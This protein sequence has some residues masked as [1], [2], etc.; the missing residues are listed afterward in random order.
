MEIE[1]VQAFTL[2]NLVT[3]FDRN[4]FIISEVI[5]RTLKSMQNKHIFYVKGHNSKSYRRK[6]TEIELI[7]AFILINLV[8]KF[9]RN[10]FI[11]SGVIARTLKSLQTN[12]LTDIRTYGRTQGIP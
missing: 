1:L 7:Q 10:P 3:K 12:G 2:I 8:T 11:I 6:V 4:P 5:A 9:E